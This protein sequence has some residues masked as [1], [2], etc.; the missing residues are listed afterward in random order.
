MTSKSLQDKAIGVTVSFFRKEWSGALLAILILALAIELVT[1]GKPFFHPTNLMTILN[2]SAAIGIVAGGMTLVILA[3]GIDLSVGSVMGLIAAVTGYIVSYW[4][5]PPW[6]AI[7]SGL[8]M[9]ALVG[10]IHGTLVAYLGMPAFIVTL[11]GLS[12][13]RG[14]AHLSTDARATPKLPETFDLFGRYNPFAELRADYKAGELSGFMESMGAFVNEHW[15][16]FFRTFQMSMIIF[17]VFFILLAVVVSNMRLGRYIYAIGS[18]EQG[19]RQAGI[20]TRLYTLYTYV[21]C[22]MGAALG[23]MLFLGRAPYA[24]SDYGQMWELDAIAAVVIGGTSLFGGRGTIIGTFMG[25][26]LL[27]L[28][29]NGLTLAQLETFWQMVVLGLIILVAVGL[30]IVRQSKSAVKVQRM[31]G[32]VALVLALFACLTPGSALISSAISLHE[33]NSMVA[34]QAAGL[35][36]AANQT[37]RLLDAPAVAEL[38][39]IVSGNWQ[40][41]ASLLVLVLGAVAVAVTLKRS[42]ALILAAVYVA[43]AVLLVSMGMAAVAPLLILGAVV[44]AGMTTV[45]YMFERAR[46][47]EG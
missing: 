24:K 16:D 31:L 27:K 38:Q 43:A 8:A 47:L 33:H 19:S 13:W 40:S 15:M 28:I 11:A 25:V 41:F 42:L 46:T 18:N 7:M 32:V 2:N 26:I 45:P 23:A 21:I 20:N 10:I 4:G 39:A 3:A 1:D 12:I 34:M 6:L 14:T 30:D 37:A 5:F 9:G 35:D 22:S 44:L 17:I 36:L 29:N